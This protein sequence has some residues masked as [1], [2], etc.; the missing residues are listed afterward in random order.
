MVLLSVIVSMAPTNSHLTD[1]QQQAVLQEAQAS[2]TQGVAMQST[3]PVASQQ[4]FK[5]AANRYQVLVSDG[6]ENGKLWY[7]L[8]NAYLQNKEV[9]EA[10][11]SYKSAQHFIPLD[12]RLRTNLAYARSLVHYP[13][14][15][16]DSATILKR[17]TFWHNAIPTQMRLYIATGCWMIL[18]ALLSWRLFRWLP[19]WKTGSVISGVAAVLIGSSVLIDMQD[20]RKHQGVLIAQDVIIRSGHSLSD[21]PLFQTPLSEGIEFELVGERTDWLQIQLPD[22]KIGWIKKQDAQIVSLKSEQ[23]YM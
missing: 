13:T 14:E 8:G 2:Y 11:A 12:S 10:I 20:Q 23:G 9:G 18:F 15:G 21:A 5:N 22:G 6:I 1:S 19:A 17:L 16:K 7:N 3:D 4:S